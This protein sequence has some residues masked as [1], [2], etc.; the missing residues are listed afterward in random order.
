MHKDLKKATKKKFASGY[1]VGGALA[2]V[3]QFIGAL[4]QGAYYKM[5]VAS[6]VSGAIGAVVSGLF[7]YYYY[8]CLK[9]YAETDDSEDSKKPTV[10]QQLIP[11][12]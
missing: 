6:I 7:V 4:V 8:L 12:K 2:T 11:K 5:I 10:M 1:L 9:A 3:V